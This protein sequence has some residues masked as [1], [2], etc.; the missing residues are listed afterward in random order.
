MSMPPHAINTYGSDKLPPNFEVQRESSYR[1]SDPTEESPHLKR[2]ELNSYEHRLGDSFTVNTVAI[3]LFFWEA[4]LLFMFARATSSDLLQAIS[5]INNKQ[6]ALK[7][8]CGVDSHLPPIETLIAVLRRTSRS[9]LE[10]RRSGIPK[11]CTVE[12]LGDK[13]CALDD[14]P[15]VEDGRRGLMK[16]MM[17]VDSKWSVRKG[18]GRHELEN[19]CWQ[20]FVISR[21]ST[22][23]AA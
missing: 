3:F 10:E 1:S 7:I 8:F 16:S 15:F 18:S 12:K 23:L 22:T 4:C 6:H 14:S 9:R 13:W 20:R 2:E 11:E 21:R 19:F 5:D 17:V